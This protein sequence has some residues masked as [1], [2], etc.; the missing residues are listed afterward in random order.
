MKTTGKYYA[1]KYK[2]T[3]CGKEKD[4]KTNH[5]GNVYE[6]CNCGNANWVCLKKCPK[7][8]QKPADWQQV[9]IGDICNLQMLEGGKLVIK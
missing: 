2:C 5:Y 7:S 4:I 9:Q 1:K 8:M 6:T 3:A